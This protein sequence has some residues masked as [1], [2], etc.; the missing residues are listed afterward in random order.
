MLGYVRRGDVEGVFHRQEPQRER[1]GGKEKKKI[2]KV[3]SIDDAKAGRKMVSHELYI[4]FNDMFA[5][6]ISSRRKKKTFPLLY[7]V[8]Y[9]FLSSLRIDGALLFPLELLLFVCFVLFFFHFFPKSLLH[10]RKNPEA[11]SM[12]HV[13]IHSV[14]VL[15]L[16]K[17]K[18]NKQ[19]KKNSIIIDW[20]TKEKIPSSFCSRKIVLLVT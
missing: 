16:D 20:I 18:T 5:E 10:N 3:F 6:P 19:T 9:R 12:N 14:A 4:F 2:W 11:C 7:S 1:E 15:L 17:N 8:F 13:A